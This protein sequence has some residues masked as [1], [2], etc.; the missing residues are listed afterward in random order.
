MVHYIGLKYLTNGVTDFI[1]IIWYY[2]ASAEIHAVLH[3]PLGVSLSGT[4]M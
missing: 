4:F 3:R 1:T 2:Y